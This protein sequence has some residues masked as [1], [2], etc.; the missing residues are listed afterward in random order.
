MTTNKRSTVP[1]ERETNQ[2]LSTLHVFARPTNE[3][4]PATTSE[5]L[6]TPLTTEINLLSS[7][8]TQ[9]SNNSSSSPTTI[10]RN[11]RLTV[12]SFET[13]V[14]LSTSSIETISSSSSPTTNEFLST[15]KIN[16]L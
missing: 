9:V 2:P 10:T 12:P 6:P 11:S 15:P 7:T 3:F 16:T 8:S 4:S 1:P 14:S 5:F 13:N